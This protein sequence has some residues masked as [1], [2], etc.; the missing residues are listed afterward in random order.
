[1]EQNRPRSIAVIA[2]LMIVFGGAEVL[3]GFT[4]DFFGLKTTQGM[5]SA[6]AGAAI[7]A[8]YSAAGLLILTM[9]RRAV[10]FAICA[11]CNC[12][13]RTYRYGRDGS[14]CASFAIL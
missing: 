2:W 10:I 5:V 14:L 6:Y 9:K 1:M 12:Y 11:S 8:L 3:T 13:R 7:G 4:H